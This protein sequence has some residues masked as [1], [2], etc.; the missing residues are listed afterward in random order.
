MHADDAPL[1]GTSLAPIN[2]RDKVSGGALYAADLKLPRMLHAKVLRSTYA[3]ARI[4]HIDASRA[5]KAPGVKAVLTGADTPKP[6]GI[7]R[8]DEHVL[9]V[10]KVRFVG[11]EVAVVVA[12]DEHAAL[13]ALEL[14]RVDY[15]ELPAVFD[16][17]EALAPG[18]PEIHAGTGNLAREI[19]FERGDV[20]RGFAEAKAVHEAVYETPYQYHAAME[21]MASVAAVDASGRLTLWA[22]VHS[23][24]RTLLRLAEVLDLPTSQIRV[25]QTMVGGSFGG[26][27][28]EDANLYIAARAALACR[29][30]VRLVNTRI[31][32]FLG[33]RPCMPSRIEL[34]MAADAEGRLTA[35][36]AEIYGDNGA[37]SGLT[38]EVILVTALRLDN[39]YRMKNIRT[40]ARLVYTN[41]IP[42]GGFRGFGGAQI[43]FAHESHMDALAE[44][45]GMDPVEFRLKNVVTAGERTV[46]DWKI[47]S[48]EVAQCLTT[49]DRLI[50]RREKRAARKANGPLRRG[51]GIGTSLHVSGA[52]QLADWDG[53]TVLL[54]FNPDG[55]AVVVCGEGDIGQGGTTMLAQIAAATLGLPLEHV[56]VSVADSESTP[57]TWG[58]VASRLTLIAGN[59]VMAAARSARRKL[60]ALAAQMLEVKEDDLTI[61]DGVIHVVGVPDLSVSVAKV[62]MA[63]QLRPG[64]EAVFARATYDAP[65]V[66]ADHKTYLGNV[67]AACSFAVQA[68][69]VEVDIET[70]TVRIVDIVAVDDVGKALNPQSVEGQIHGAIAQGAGYA[71]HEQLVLENGRLLNGNLADYVVP[72]ALSFPAP[73]TVIVDGYEPNGPY[74]A[75]GASEAPISATAGA[76]ANAV[77][78]AIGVRITSL[79]ITP[80]KVLEALRARGGA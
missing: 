57:Y 45:L 37:Y 61:K 18:A 31:E 43:A 42:S 23:V 52:R 13:D 7:M 67:S 1:I 78:D 41:K 30:P 35:K 3:H 59:A 68:I 71:L 20:E 54:K 63:H 47:S 80:E 75:K 33:A 28:G 6:W 27:L 73:R 79:P 55:R 44:K 9:A 8:K 21:P 36:Q 17:R 58:A 76:I 14:I 69:E 26:K 19:A 32:D 39:L 38:P 77:Y 74:G 65:T 4:R 10:D 53:S 51:I 16:M 29:A 60:L 64:G 48:C 5:L 22:P 70:G 46:H 12:S 50:R 15:E 62:C 40:R 25:V 72:N 34:K 11:E 49:A 2:A 56:S 24:H 66:V